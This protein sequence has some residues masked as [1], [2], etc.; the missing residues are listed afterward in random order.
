MLIALTLAMMALGA[1]PAFFGALSGFDLVIGGSGL[2]L[3][4]LF[5]IQTLVTARR[6][7][8]DKP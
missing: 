8:R 1:G 7:A 3:I 2:V 4:A 5:V 6:L